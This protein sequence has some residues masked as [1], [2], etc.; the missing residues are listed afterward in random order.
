MELDREPLEPTEPADLEPQTEPFAPPFRE[1]SQLALCEGA[2]EPLPR[3]CAGR[4][5][6]ELD[7]EVTNI[8]QRPE[9][10]PT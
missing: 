10:K 7:D 6:V 8:L 2:I 1:P 4:G 5:T 9:P 3:A